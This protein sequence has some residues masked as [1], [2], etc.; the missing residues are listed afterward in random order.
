MFACATITSCATL[1]GR[2]NWLRRR[3]NELVGDATI[4]QSL[5]Q[6][7]GGMLNDALA[8]LRAGNA[9][10]VETHLESFVEEVEEHI[11][12]SVL[13][14]DGPALVD[15]AEDIIGDL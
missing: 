12:G 6:L 1:E 13:Y 7:L 3:V 2:I 5:G 11:Q 8:A 10:S 4:S 15:A 9:S 14:V